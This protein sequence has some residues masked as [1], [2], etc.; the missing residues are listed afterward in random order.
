LGA[1]LEQLRVVQ[2][3]DSVVD[4]RQQE[5]ELLEQL[6]QLLPVMRC[7][8]G[9]MQHL[10]TDDDLYAGIMTPRQRLVG[11]ARK[12]ID[13][14][15]RAERLD[16]GYGFL[17]SELPYVW[18]TVFEADMLTAFEQPHMPLYARKLCVPQ[19]V[20]IHGRSIILKSQQ[21][22]RRIKFSCEL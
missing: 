13:K 7:A 10:F 8:L 21:L 12:E 3:T 19:H 11:S 17:A 18:P 4:V 14:M 22:G 1:I 16:F 6:T 9:T 5:E 15:S 20:A 2:N